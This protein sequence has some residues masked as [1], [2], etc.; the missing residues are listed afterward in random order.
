MANQK[1]PGQKKTVTKSPVK[2]TPRKFRDA[3][4]KN[5]GKLLD[6]NSS[7]IRAAREKNRS[8]DA[9]VKMI[10]QLAEKAHKQ[11][12][13][14]LGYTNLEAI[15]RGYQK[16]TST[17]KAKAVTKARATVKRYKKGSYKK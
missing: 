6:E 10:E 13:K 3:Y 17:P 2:I 1:K 5:F 9:G 11:T 7:K 4:D 8:T 16:R 15:E 12:E 14:E